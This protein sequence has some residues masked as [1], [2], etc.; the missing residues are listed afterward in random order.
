MR[1]FDVEQASDRWFEIRKGVP[2]ASCF[3]RILTPKKG[4]FSSQ[5]E[6]YANQLIG[7]LFS[8]IPP[9]GIENATTRAMRWGTHCE[10]EA[11]R[12]YSMEKDVDL[13]NGGFCMSNDGRFGCSPDFLVGLEPVDDEFRKDDRGNSFVLSV[14]KAAGEMKCPQPGTQV[15]YLRSKELP[16]EY[17]WQVHG[18]LIVTGAEYVDF[19]SYSPGLAPLVVRVEPGEDTLTLR[20]ALD[21]FHAKYTAALARVKEMA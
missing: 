5:A 2:T 21:E 14:C 20:R 4:E 19:L 13:A 11:R 1:Y 15:K 6:D 8:L 17:R 9:E 10:E 16:A 7:D 18:H 12:Y 3:D